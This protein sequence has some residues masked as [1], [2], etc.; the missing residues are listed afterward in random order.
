MDIERVEVDSKHGGG[1]S[2]GKV[3]NRQI[4][5][6]EGNGHDRMSNLSHEDLI[7][8]LHAETSLLKALC[9]SALLLSIFC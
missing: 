6:A 3:D 8:Q 5:V 1:G 2:K 4:A 7:T 9:S